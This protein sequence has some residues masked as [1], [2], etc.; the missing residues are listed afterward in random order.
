MDVGR[1]VDVKITSQ[2]ERSVTGIE[3]PLDL[4]HASLKALEAL[5]GV[6]AKRAARIVRSRPFADLDQFAAALDDA[7]IAGRIRAFVSLAS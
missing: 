4:N 5:P 7:T 6:G 1:F 3:F 2:G